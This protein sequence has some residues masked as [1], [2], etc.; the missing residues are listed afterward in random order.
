MLHGSILLGALREAPAKGR[1]REAP[2]I[3]QAPMVACVRGSEVQTG[4]Q[5]ARY[6]AFIA[7]SRTQGLP[8]GLLG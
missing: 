3:G 5:P 6:H 7:V 4:W 1:A 8:V 2:A